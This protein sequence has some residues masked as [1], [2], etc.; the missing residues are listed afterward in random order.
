MAKSLIK[1]FQKFR[2]A[3][4]FWRPFAHDVFEFYLGVASDVSYRVCRWLQC[5]RHRLRVD[6]AKI[7]GRCLKPP[8]TTAC[9][10]MTNATENPVVV[11]VIKGGEYYDYSYFFVA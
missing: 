1:T 5:G 6:K 8:G 2:F 9:F 3:Y 10:P 11:M 4:L 7:C